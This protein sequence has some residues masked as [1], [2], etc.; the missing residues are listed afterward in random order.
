MFRQLPCEQQAG[1]W[2]EHDVAAE[3]VGSGIPDCWKGVCHG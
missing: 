3:F 2:N 1:I